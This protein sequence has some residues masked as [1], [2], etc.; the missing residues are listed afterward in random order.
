[1]NTVQDTPKIVIPYVE[2]DDIIHTPD[3]PFCSD[4]Q[5]PCHQDPE[6]TEALTQEWLDGLRSTQ[7]S[8]D[9]Y[10]NVAQDRNATTQTQSGEWW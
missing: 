5:C 4:L 7:E 2:G 9:V 3:H 1:M 6:L 8:F 10:W